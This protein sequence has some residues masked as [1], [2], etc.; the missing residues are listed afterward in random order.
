MTEMVGMAIVMMEG[1]VE[2]RAISLHVSTTSRS[3]IGK[4]GWDKFEKLAT[5]AQIASNSTLTTM[6]TIS[7][8]YIKYDFWMKFMDITF[9]SH[10][11]TRVMTFTSSTSVL[12]TS[13]SSSWIIDS[14]ASTHMLSTS[15]IFC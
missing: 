9:M 1:K 12:L 11:V 14:E 6:F 13:K 7:L 4:Q 5:L 10:V 3:I 15:T 2:V 8:S